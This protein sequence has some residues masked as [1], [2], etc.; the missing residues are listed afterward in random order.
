MSAEIREGQIWQEVDPRYPNA[1]HKRVCGF[2]AQGK[3][4]LQ[5]VGIAGRVTRAKPE[6]FNNKRGG[7]R[8]ISE[9]TDV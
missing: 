3:I 6:R 9:G 8:L 4:I 5:P 2:D 1:V 7:Y